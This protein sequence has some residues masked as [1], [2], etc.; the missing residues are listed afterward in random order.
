[1]KSGNAIARP[2]PRDNQFRQNKSKYIATLGICDVRKLQSWV[3]ASWTLLQNS[4]SWWLSQVIPN[5][6][7]RIPAFN[8]AMAYVSASECW[9]DWKS[10][11][12]A[13]R[14][15]QS[16]K[17]FNR[18]DECKPWQQTF[19]A[20]YETFCSRTTMLDGWRRRLLQSLLHGSLYN[21]WGL[22]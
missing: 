8:T 15:I 9:Y 6:E 14:K 19:Y 4:P 5:N 3:Y 20:V 1:M 7:N 2:R 11:E 22:S 10:R 18:I 13:I 17:S 12:W 16:Y 21:T